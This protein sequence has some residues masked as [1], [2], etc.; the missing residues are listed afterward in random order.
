MNTTSYSPKVQHLAIRLPNWLGDICMVLP[1]LRAIQEKAK[2]ENPN[3]QFTLFVQSPYISLLEKLGV[4]G[5]VIALPRKNWRYFFTFL[6]WRRQFDVFVLFTNSE[7]GDIE[8]WL[9]GAKRRYGIAR[10]NK[11]RKLLTHRYLLDRHFDEQSLHQTYL[12]EQ[13]A[14]YFN[15]LDDLD[16]SPFARMQSKK[17]QVGLICGS[18]NTPEKRWSIENWQQLIER[19]LKLFDAVLLLGTP[20]DT[21]VCQQIQSGVSDISRVINLAGQTNLA[22]LIDLM[23]QQTLIIGN[24]TGGLHL[25]NALGVPVIGLYGFTNSLRCHPIFSAPMAII[26]SPKGYKAGQMSD[27]SVEMVLGKVEAIIPSLQEGYEEYIDK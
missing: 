3:V 2:V 4:E 23:R 6:T 13:F 18:A 5:E 12:W 9:T 15:L 14:Q 10:P 21:A 8:A 26:D 11:P 25:A 24:D 7:R 19:L 1:I 27:I 17:R 20:S 16:L 22:E